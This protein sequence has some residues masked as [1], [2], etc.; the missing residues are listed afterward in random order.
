M[1]KQ[2]INNAV[3][4]VTFIIVWVLSLAICLTVVWLLNK[5]EIFLV[6]AYIFAFTISFYM[7]NYLYTELNILVSKLSVKRRDNAK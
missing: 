2:A 5:Y 4:Y 3:F 6:A 1:N 7:A